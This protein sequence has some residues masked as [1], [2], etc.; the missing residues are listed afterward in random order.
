MSLSHRLSKSRFITGLQCHRELWWIVHE[1]D[2]PELVPG[3]EQQAIF[4][5]GTRVG[6]VARSYVPGGTLIDRPH[7][8]YDGR[9][10]ATRSALTDGAP[11]IYEASFVA[12]DV[13][14]AVDILVR[15]PDGWRVIEVK[16]SV[17]VKDQ[18]IPDAAVQMHVLRRAG[19]TVTGAEVMHL[20]RDC[21][22]PDLGDLFAREDV[23]R[24]VEALLPDVPRLLRGQIAALEGPLPVV[25]IGPH[26][27]EP[28]ECPFTG[29]CWSALPEHHVSTLHGVNRRA[30][31]F[32][33]RGW[34]TVRDLP[35]D[36]PL[37]A[38]ADRQRRA[39]KAGR[40]LVEGDLAGAL[41][42]FEGPLAFLDFETV[43]PAIP[44]WNGCHPYDQI[45]AQ[46]SCHREGPGGALDH[47]E[48]VADGPADPRGEVAGRVIDACRDARTV[49]AYNMSF[50][51]GCLEAMARALPARAKEL[52]DVIGRLADPLPVIRDHIYHPDFRGSFSL[53]SVLPA[54]IP[55]FTYDDLE[56]PDGGLASLLLSRLVLGGPM[57]PAERGRRRK[58]LL[59][60]C[61]RDTLAL[62]RLMERLR[63]IAERGDLRSP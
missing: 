45:A 44:V 56:I 55:G 11:A 52:E 13:F 25:P 10:G 62:V 20:N 7:R 5:Q 50:E 46:F 2:A 14:V 17:S 15:E 27:F 22:Y 42:S 47:F 32:E 3:P 19:L 1:P 4:D 40:M 8:D 31:D 60:Y 54:L 43:L 61:E 51:R 53:K 33:A 37:S 26:C 6:E 58:A 28:H 21:A 59:A 18:H 48:W 30:A 29:R 57:E 34:H 36:V 12:D 9:I 38:A 39:V 24:E 16:S 41:S 63:E 49:I 35:D 23:T